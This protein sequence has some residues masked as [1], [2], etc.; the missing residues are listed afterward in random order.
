[1]PQLPQYRSSAVLN[2][3]RGA[4]YLK[5]TNDL[6]DIANDIQA[7]GQR[8]QIALAKFNEK[9]KKVHNENQAAKNEY[10][11]K[12]EVENVLADFNQ[13]PDDFDPDYIEKTITDLHTKYS[14]NFDDP[15]TQSKW[16]EK[17]KYYAAKKIGTAKQIYNKAV[18][19]K[20]NEYYE[21]GLNEDAQKP[22]QER[23]LAMS[24]RTAQAIQ[25]GIISK[26]KALEKM[27]DALAIGVL[28][29][30]QTGQ[31]GVDSEG[32]P[33]AVE[34][35]SIYK[36]LLDPND[37]TYPLDPKKKNELLSNVRSFINFAEKTEKK[38]QVSDKVLAQRAIA[39]I[40][41]NKSGKYGNP[42]EQLNAIKDLGLSTEYENQ[43]IKALTKAEKVPLS[44]NDK[45]FKDLSIDISRLNERFKMVEED[46]DAAISYIEEINKFQEKALQLKNNGK[47]GTASYSDIMEQL[48]EKTAKNTEF[49]Y[50]TVKDVSQVDEFG[51]DEYDNPDVVGIFE[52]KYGTDEADGMFREFYKRKTQALQS[53]KWKEDS[54][55]NR[56]ELINT[57]IKEKEAKI[58][59]DAYKIANTYNKPQTNIQ[60]APPVGEFEQ[61]PQTVE[62]LLDS[63]IDEQDIIDNLEHWTNKGKSEQWVLNMLMQKHLQK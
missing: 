22:P 24:E 11:F 1:M 12:T 61:A 63:G 38:K 51:F 29:D 44:I 13:Y 52:D 53:G 36:K 50:G 4:D 49:A 19:K 26:P 3:Q 16:F 46:E 28:F 35:R 45:T 9:M 33:Q 55:K 20:A 39:E 47:I 7:E 40:V 25:D 37:A 41:T 6:L 58:K 21:M 14:E 30:I 59:G 60:E 8:R 31:M 48:E 23:M 56:E 2:P 10:Q 17:N 42:L 62:N 5:P 27:Q 18:I 43:G 54:N 15:E 32:N 57:M 34:A